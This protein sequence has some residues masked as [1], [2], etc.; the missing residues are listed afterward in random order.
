MSDFH[1]YT[2]MKNMDIQKLRGRFRKREFE[3]RT[4]DDNT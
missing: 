1:F 3:T 4:G 2:D